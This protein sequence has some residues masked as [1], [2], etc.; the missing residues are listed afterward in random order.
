[1]ERKLHKKQEQ[2]LQSEKLA[3]MGRL[4]S[5][6]AHE[7]NNPLYGIMNTLELMKT[8]IPAGNK[9]RKLLE[10]SLS[11]T[12]RV[13]DMLRKMLSFSKPDQEERAPVDINTI[14][15]EIL[16]LHEKQLWEYSIKVVHSF[17]DNLGKIH[18]SKN[19]LRQVFLN[20]ISNARDAMPD[21]GRL[22]VATEGDDYFIHI[23]V[24]DNGV[25]IKEEHLDL[26]F[27]T[28]FTTKTDSVKG[29]GLGLSVCYGFIKDHG[30]DIKVDSRPGEGTTFTISLPVI[31]PKVGNG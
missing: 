20:L 14:L 3:A 18:A 11:E 4:T 23:T 6:I 5:Q 2:L 22:T 28:F 16:L 19:Q 12:V 30:G 1:M 15:D 24:S 21:G 26:V 13:T 27:E 31:R 10:M 9:R 17:A 8:E 25:G 7:L 29:V